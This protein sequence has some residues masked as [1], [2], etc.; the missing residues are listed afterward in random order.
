MPNSISNRQ[1]FFIIYLTLTSYT[2]I[3][4]PKLMAQ[5]AG[6]SSWITI[7]I[8]ALIYSVAAVILTKLNNTFQGKV[9]FDYSQEIVGKFF[10]YLIAVFYFLVSIMIGVYIKVKLVNLLTANFLHQTPQFAL[11]LIGILA[12]GYVAYK[13]ITNIA[14]MY[15]IIGLLY[16]IVTIILCLFMIFEGMA[17]N[18]LP[19]YEKSDLEEFFPAIKN[20]IIPFTGL[21][22]LLVIPFSEKNKK[23]PKVAFIAVLFIGLF[24]ILTVEST[25]MILGLINTASFNDAFIEATKMVKFPVIERTDILYLTFGLTSLFAGA[26]IIYTVAVEFACR[27]FSSLKRYVIVIGISILLFIVSLFCLNITNFGEIYSS[28][29]PYVLITTSILI[30]TVLFIIAKLKKGTG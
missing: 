30:P 7:L 15:E 25:I 21:G 2:T 23:A 27:L 18:I 17:E 22:V 9:L 1:M 13:G 12:F 4:L 19:F 16:L 14:R 28:I 10:A 3:E 11:L 24:Y 8:A 6:R 20:L 26:I 29:A 5:T